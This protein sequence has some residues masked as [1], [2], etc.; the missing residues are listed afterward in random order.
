[1]MLEMDVPG[2]GHRTARGRESPRL[3][4]VILLLEKDLCSEAGEPL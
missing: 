2:R 4:P 1:M 3:A